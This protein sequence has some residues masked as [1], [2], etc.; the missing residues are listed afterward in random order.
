MCDPCESGSCSGVTRS[1]PPSSGSR[2]PIPPLGNSW[3][4]NCQIN[5]VMST[6]YGLGFSVWLG[7]H[8]R[9]NKGLTNSY[10]YESGCCS[11]NTLRR[12]RLFQHELLRHSC[13]TKHQEI[14]LCPKNLTKSISCLVMLVASPAD[15]SNNLSP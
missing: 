1:L 6:N 5:H 7:R 4:E 11:R 8:C 12:I 10:G 15:S 9:L 3:S 2:G 14:S 13:H